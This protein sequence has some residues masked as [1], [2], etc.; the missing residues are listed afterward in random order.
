[1]LKTEEQELTLEGVLQMRGY[2]GALAT[3][4]S[5]S[6]NVIIHKESVTQQDA[7]VI[8]ELVMR[9][10]GIASGNVKIIPII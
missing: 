3:V 2:D 7:A 8:L 10:T 9:E 1:M 5:D 4:H 6:V